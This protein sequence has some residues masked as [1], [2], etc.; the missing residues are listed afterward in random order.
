M[1][2]SRSPYLYVF[3][4][5]VAL[6]LAELGV[7]YVPGIGNVLLVAALV[8]LAVAK[9]GLVL[10]YFMHLGSETRALK[11]MVLIPFSLP[12]LFALVLITEATWRFLR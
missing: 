4:T 3:L 12:A 8:L 2:A 1:S 6:T 10:I 7:V 9:A 5:L 11:L